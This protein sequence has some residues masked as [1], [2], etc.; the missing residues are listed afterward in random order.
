MN[1][2]NLAT[3]T[4]TILPVNDPPVAADDSVSTD[5]D[6]PI[7]VDVLVNDNDIDEDILSVVEVSQPDHGTSSTNGITITYTP[8]ANYCGSDGFIY[9]VSDVSGENAAVR[10]E[11]NFF[12]AS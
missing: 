12:A 3:V 10:N 5:E 4:L 9:T 7:T 2:S 8:E 11:R 1:S 6:T